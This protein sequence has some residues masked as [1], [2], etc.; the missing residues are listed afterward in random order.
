MTASSDSGLIKSPN[1][2]ANG[3]RRSSPETSNK[4]TSS[5]SISS[6]IE[7]TKSSACS[8]VKKATKAGN[9]SVSSI[10]ADNESSSLLRETNVNCSPRIQLMMASLSLASIASINPSNRDPI[11]SSDC[12]FSFLC[13]YRFSPAVSVT[14]VPP[15]SYG[16]THEKWNDLLIIRH[17]RRRATM[18]THE[19]RDFARFAIDRVQVEPLQ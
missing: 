1:S 7:S 12:I 2:F 17:S 6:A 19:R 14:N 9:S 5:P 10:M 13:N 15:K 8:E 16:A 18:H 4:S 3:P 11:S